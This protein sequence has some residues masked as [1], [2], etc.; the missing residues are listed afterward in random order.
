MSR[1]RTSEP[2][3][4]G[5]YQIETGLAGWQIVPTLSAQFIRESI[6]SAVMTQFIRRKIFSTQSGEFVAA[7]SQQLANQEMTI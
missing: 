1:K 6:V 4:G 2:P 3:R 7:V 5:H